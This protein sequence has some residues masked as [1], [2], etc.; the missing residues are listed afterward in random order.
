M[1]LL[2]ICGAL[3]AG[4]Y[5]ASLVPCFSGLWPTMALVAVFIVLF[6]YGLS[7]RGWSVAFFVFFGLT[8]HFLAATKDEA[9]YRERPWLRGRPVRIQRTER[10][11]RG[12]S[13]AIRADLSRR[14]G[15]GVASGEETVLLSRAIL[16]GERRRLSPSL[17]KLFVDS[18]TMHVF[19]ISGLHVGAV[20]NVIAVLLA[21]TFVSRRFLHLA[22][23]PALWG[24]VY[25][26]GLPPSAVR[27]ALMATFSALA[28]LFWRRPDG[29][30][31]WSLTFLLVHVFNPQQIANVGSVLSFGVMLAII[32]AG[33]LVRDW[34]KWKQAVVLTAAAWAVGV[35]I[36]AHV[37][38]RVTP[39]GLL[40][41][42]V[43]IA[44]ARL[45]VFAGAL[46]VAASFVSQSL[47][48]HLNNLSALAIRTMVLV[49]EAVARIP[50]ANL[51]T[52][53]WEIGTCMLWYAGVVLLG[54]GV[55]W[56]LHRR[57]FL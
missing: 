41:N 40:S 39:G 29:V 22:A 13:C 24:Y 25:L 49:T 28:P 11:E 42:L 9:V 19:A 51:E 48:A 16:L 31:S 23:L 15:V 35:P 2:L 32:L 43:L 50:G 37:F 56:T 36:A 46:G 27:A 5:A 10:P 18:G 1:R 45:V 33:S 44:V 38:G 34:P 14:V 21:L 57:R 20:A 3:A 52:G 7:V 30:R 53:P 8:L 26:I 54:A 47:A 4:E 17:K 12:V 6:G 55:Y